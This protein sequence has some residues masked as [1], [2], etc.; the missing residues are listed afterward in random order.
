VEV[1]YG[2]P[3][4]PQQAPSFKPAPQTGQRN[5]KT[6]PHNAQRFPPVGEARWREGLK[7]NLSPTKYGT[8][9]G[10]EQSGQNP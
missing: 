7:N 2:E 8:F 9:D 5:S 6:S 10:H 3:Q 1:T 4:T